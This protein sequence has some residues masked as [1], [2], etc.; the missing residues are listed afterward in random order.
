[1]HQ[2]QDQL[3]GLLKEMILCIFHREESNPKVWSTA[4][5]ALFYFLVEGGKIDHAKYS[6]LPF[7]SNSAGYCP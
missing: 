1:M 5:R 2:I 3:F 6:P 7:S 4:L